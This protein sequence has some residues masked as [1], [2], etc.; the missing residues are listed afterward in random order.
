MIELF[1]SGSYEQLDIFRGTVETGFGKIEGRTVYHYRLSGMIGVQDARKIA[2]L[3]QLALKTGSPIIGLLDSKGTSLSEG[4]EYLE[5]CGMIM[6]QLCKA[7]GVIP[8]LTVIMGDCIGLLAMVSRLSDF[9]LMVNGRLCL[10][11]PT[12]YEKEPS[13]S[14]EGLVHFACRDQKD[15]IQ[16]IKNLLSYLPQNNLDD[17]PAYEPIPPIS[18]LKPKSGS[19]DNQGIDFVRSLVDASE[20]LELQKG[21]GNSLIGFSRLEG[22]TVGMILLQ[23]KLGPE[24]L[25]KAVGFIKLCNSFHIPLLTLTD[26]DGFINGNTKNIGADLDFNYVKLC[27]SFLQ[28][29][30]KARIPK[31]QVYIGKAVGSFSILLNSKQAADIVL[32]CD[33]ASFS[34]LS[35]EG[36]TKIAGVKVDD[37]AEN[38]LLAGLVDSVIKPEEA[39]RCLSNFL[40]MLSTKRQAVRL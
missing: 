24:D 22:Y 27:S 28:D 8:Q 34:V 31:I 29:L 36:L 23:G 3:Y 30:S 2:N 20:I 6:D 38:A 37:K 14:N 11:S 12:V 5:A 19:Q 18:N 40:D 9:V 25:D 4:L 1:D 26:V 16:Q 10:Q 7:S 21:Y 17:P 35:K 33:H 13:S 15:C 39:R 32:A